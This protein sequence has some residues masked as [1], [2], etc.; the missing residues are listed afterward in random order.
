MAYSKTQR[1][2]DQ[3]AAEIMVKMARLSE[4]NPKL[5]RQQCYERVVQKMAA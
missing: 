2:G 5:S 1:L 4:A 3:L